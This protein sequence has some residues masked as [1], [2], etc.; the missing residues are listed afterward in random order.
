MATA[1]FPKFAGILHA[2]LSQHH[3]LGFEIVSNPKMMLPK[4][5]HG[6]KLTTCHQGE[7]L[8]PKS[9]PDWRIELLPVLRASLKIS[10][11]TI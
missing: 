5:Y 1:E 4:A 7:F 11:V 3:L 2:A 10:S 6:K 9:C 8:H